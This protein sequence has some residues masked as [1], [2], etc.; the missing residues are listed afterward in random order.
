[1][2]TKHLIDVG[3]TSGFPTLAK[4]LTSLSSGPFLR[5]IQLRGEGN[6]VNA[7]LL[8]LSCS[9]TVDKACELTHVGAELHARLAQ[10]VVHHVANDG[11]K[12]SRGFSGTSQRASVNKAMSSHLLPFSFDAFG[13]PPPPPP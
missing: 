4:L 8:F 2:R 11:G 1:M 7:Q 12:Y 10:V 9:H 6:M 13:L 3:I 5:I